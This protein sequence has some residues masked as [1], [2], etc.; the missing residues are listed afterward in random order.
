MIN[1]LQH[2][3]QLACRPR[4]PNI[5]S[6]V[7]RLRRHDRVAERRAPESRLPLQIVRAAIDD[8]RAKPTFV[9]R[10]TPLRVAG[11]HRPSSCF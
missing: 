3:L 1:P 4:E 6:I 8:Q 5:F 11:Q 7:A 2:D 9:H 10:Q